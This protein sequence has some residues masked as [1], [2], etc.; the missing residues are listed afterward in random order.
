[1]DF[2]R[3]YEL[4]YDLR[5]RIAEDYDL[6]ARCMAAGARYF[7]LPVPTYFYRRHAG[8]TS[9][10]QSVADLAAML[11]AADSAAVGSYDPALLA[12]VAVREAG[13]RSALR[14][15]KALDS[16]KAR[17]LFGALIAIGYD[18]QAWRLM[19]QTIREGVGRRLHRSPSPG[20]AYRSAAL[21]L[22]TPPAGSAQ[23]REIARLAADGVAIEYRDPVADDTARANLADGLPPLSHIF[24]APPATLDDAAYAMAPSVVCDIATPT[25]PNI[26]GSSA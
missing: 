21:V 24:V 23:A 11:L 4:R 17:S 10:R 25:A 15:A 12:A 5:L 16:L 22:G 13:I 6:V 26:A 18:S 8:S 1:M 3:Q 2:L 7:Y 14:H 9:H 20:A 19:V